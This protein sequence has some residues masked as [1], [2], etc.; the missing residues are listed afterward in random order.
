MQA[1]ELGQWPFLALPAC[2]C[3]TSCGGMGV[4][5]VSKLREVSSFM[6]IIRFMVYQSCYGCPKHACI[7]MH[8]PC[9]AHGALDARCVQVSK[10][11][12]VQASG[13]DTSQMIERLDHEFL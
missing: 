9:G 13:L 3:A 1:Q 5:V 8:A 11:T 6:C 12:V 7:L 4:W 10:S 2:A